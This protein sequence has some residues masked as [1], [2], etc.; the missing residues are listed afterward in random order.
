[1]GE[2]PQEADKPIYG[3]PNPDNVHPFDPDPENPFIGL[4]AKVRQY[5]LDTI[6]KPARWIRENIVEANRGEKYYW[7]HRRYPRALPIDECYSDDLAC[8][9]EAN[10]EF[11]RNFLVDREAL[12]L[13]RNRFDACAFRYVNDTKFTQISDKCDSLREIYEE[14]LTNFHIKYGDM[15]T[16]ATVTDAYMKQKHRM[17]MERRQALKRQERE[18]NLEAQAS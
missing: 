15:R 6:R 4:R 1:M 8:I 2:R 12:T 5:A 9:Y 11:R 14:N 16:A 7:Y 3:P 13:L 18:Q 10:A 17:I